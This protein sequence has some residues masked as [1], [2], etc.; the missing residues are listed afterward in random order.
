MKYDQGAELVL[1]A[2]KGIHGRYKKMYGQVALRLDD[3]SYLLTVGNRILSEI[4]EESLIVCDINSGDLGVIFR[5]RQDINA[6]IVGVTKDMVA[7]S[8]DRDSMST[9]LEDLAQLTGAELK[10]IPDAAPANILKALEKT[11]VCLIRGTGGIATGSN[12]KKAVAGIQIV[13]KACEAEV[14]GR[15]IGGT[16]PIDEAAA[17]QYRKEF[18]KDY[19]NRNEEKNVPFIGYD[20]EE[21]A[22]RSKL[23]E[24]G[25]EMVKRDLTYGSWGNLSARLNEE[26]MLITPS[27]IDYFEIKP[28]D[29]VRMNINTLTYSDPR[30]PSNESLMHAALY[31]QF[32]ECGG[33]VH[34]HSNGISVF[35]ACEAGFAVNEPE[36]KNLIGDIKVAKYAPPGSAELAASVTYTMQGTHSVI[37][38]HHGAV[39]TGPTPDMAFSIAEAVEIRAR[40]IL[41]FDNSQVLE[42][43][44]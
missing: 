17:K 38:P 34:T 32:P 42:E 29:I 44:K 12:L 2:I 40:S 36:V 4:G 33:I 25:E 19:V 24:L 21:F 20:E 8:S 41:D 35:A 16:V 31:R 9:T 1:D 23:I 15:L 6:V 7:V 28:E 3:E 37:I 5:S 26:E 43:E 14:H 30:T 10:V 13:E 22:L 18:R 11:S 39:F 27:S